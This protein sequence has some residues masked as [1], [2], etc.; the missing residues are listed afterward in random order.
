MAVFP[1]KPWLSRLAPDF[2]NKRFWCEV[3]W[4]DVFLTPSSR[5][6]GL[7]LV[8]IHWTGRASLRSV[9]SFQC[10]YPK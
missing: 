10:H 1:D 6:T 7:H 4:L 3:L 2:P 5:N 9:S 8:C